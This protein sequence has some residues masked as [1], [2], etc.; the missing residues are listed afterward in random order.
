MLR[1]VVAKRRYDLLAPSGERLRSVTIS[2]GRPIKDGDHDYRCFF[3]IDGLPWGGLLYAVGTD[4]V[5]ALLLAM[6][7]AGTHLYH[8]EEFKEGLITLDG[9]PNLGLPA[10]D[11]DFVP[12]PMLTLTV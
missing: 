6:V 7:R 3:R 8:S 12:D 5:S 4:A 2:F 10:I 11:G 9:S 1:H